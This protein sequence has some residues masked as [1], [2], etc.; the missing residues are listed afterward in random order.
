MAIRK[1]SSQQQP[2]TPQLAKTFATMKHLSGE[3]PLKEPRKNFFRKHLKNGTFNSPTW[4]IVSEKGSKDEYRADGQHTSTVLSECGAEH[5]PVGLEVTIIKWEIDSIKKDSGP[6]FD[7]FDHPGSAR[8]SEDKMSYYKASHPDLEGMSPAFL[9]KVGAGIGIYRRNVS[10]KAK[11]GQT[12]LIY[13]SR[14]Q[15]VYFDDEECR[16]FA[17][18]AFRWRAARNSWLFKESVLIASMMQNWFK[19]QESATTFWGEVFAASNPDP[20]S[21]TRELADTLKDTKASSRKKKVAAYMKAADRCWRVYR[22]ESQKQEV[23]A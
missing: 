15:G 11:E 21:P 9:C 16:K 7:Q 4:H 14:E 22:A 23:A 10:A 2:L 12:L 3:R 20:D 19:A 1:L 5:F 6:L 8:N 17:L 13:S 18:W